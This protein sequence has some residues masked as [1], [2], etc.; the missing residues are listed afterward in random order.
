MP[1]SRP[2]T[3]LGHALQVLRADEHGIDDLVREAAWAARRVGRGGTAPLGPADLADL[4]GMLQ[5][6]TMAAGTTLFRAGQRSTGVWLVRDG[7]IEMLLGSRRRRA[8]VG[9]LRPG[10]VEGDIPLLLEAPLPYTARTV[11]D[12]TCLFLGRRDFEALLTERPA[13][14]RRWMASVAQ[15]LAAGQTR[16]VS[17]LGQAL[18]RQAV[19]V[20]L[21]EA[22]EG[23]VRMPQRTLAAMLGVQRPSL[24]K[25]L[26]ELERDGLIA[27]RYAAI[28]LVDAKR[29]ADLA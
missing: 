18:A 2:A 24:N 26:K 10:D 5:H 28:H 8:L 13:L 25:I 23:V 6:R 16:V 1:S 3:A 9:M 12:T 11:S 29:L 14:A 22:V 21:D 4:A 19:Q 17:L 27:V 7:R 20:L 15:R